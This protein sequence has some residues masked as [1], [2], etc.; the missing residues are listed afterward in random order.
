MSRTA[1]R[2]TQGMT[3]L[4]RARPEGGAFAV[5]STARKIPP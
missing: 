3:D 5:H 2:T 1:S 4:P